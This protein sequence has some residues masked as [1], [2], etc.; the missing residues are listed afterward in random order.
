M[1]FL[2]PNQQRQATEGKALKAGGRRTAPKQN[3]T[4]LYNDNLET[5]IS[6]ETWKNFAYSVTPFIF[7]HMPTLQRCSAFNTEN[8]FNS[9]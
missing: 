1:P 7:C 5:M 3:A 6:F 8:V 2:P 4:Q 9:F